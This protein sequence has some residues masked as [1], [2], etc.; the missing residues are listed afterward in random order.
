M[1]WTTA[2]A[3]NKIIAET[4]LEVLKT[5][6]HDHVVEYVDSYD[7]TDRKCIITEFCAGGDLKVFLEN[8]VA[9]TTV[10]EDLLLAWLWQMACGLEVC[11]LSCLKAQSLP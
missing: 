10:P 7:M 3:D 2:N 5:L 8:L 9:E 4:E 1:L 11:L 6:N